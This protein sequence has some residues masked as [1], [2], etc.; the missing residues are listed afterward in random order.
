MLR[1]P[2]TPHVKGI[3]VREL[4][5]RVVSSALQAAVDA[6]ELPL[7]SLPDPAVERP[8]EAAH[9]DWA[10]T[11]ALRLAKQARMNPRQ[12]A[13]IVAAHIEENEDIESVEVAGPGFINLR[14]APSCLQRVLEEVRSQ[15]GDYG[16]CDLGAGQRIQ[17]EFV[18][19]NPT[20]PMHVGHGRWAALGDS[21]A[22]VL[23]HAGYEVEREF[24]INDAGNQ[25]DL[26]AESVSLRYLELCGQTIEF[27]ANAYGG[28]YIID[29]AREIFED[30]GGTWAERTEAEREAYFKERAYTQVLAHMKEVLEQ[31]GVTFDTWFSERS[32]YEKDAEGRNAIERAIGLLRE[33]GYIYEKEG[34]TWFKSTDFGDDK[35]RVLVKAD[36]GYTYFAP[37]IAYHFDKFTRVDRVIDIWGAD[38]H[39]YV[40]RMQAACTALGNGGK[41]D[42]IIG[43]LVNLL[44]DGK[45]VRLSKRTGTMITFEE[46]LTEVGRDATRY[47]MISRS[48]DQALDFDIEVAKKEDSTNPVFYV[49]YAHARICSILRKAGEVPDE[50]AATC[51]M[52]ALASTLIP[53]RADL[54]VLIAPEELA[55]MRKLSEFGEVVAG[56]A[57]DYAPF[58]LTHY[59][60]DLAGAF[61][62][63]YTRC[64]VLTDDRVLTDARL[65]ALDASRIVLRLVLALLGVS[66][67]VKM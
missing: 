33:G 5:E 24:Y 52:D 36:G 15:G 45:P 35:D 7:D 57:R 65:C 43:Q 59:A 56:A 8:R 20:G 40:M 39:G 28:A 42:V 30:V 12:I 53:D 51:D 19:A 31:A 63:F 49:Q 22:N 32:L 67:P 9:G 4:M 46:L 62:Q 54:S 3:P 14:L 27:P 1:V 47:L 48:T 38:H 6:G 21:L 64:H 18:S 44:R 34:A 60:A 10:T 41:L 58:R 25:M 2:A 26:F 13:E 11:V 61:H 29:I 23:A 55:L 66:A 50:E 16:K 17:V 37:D